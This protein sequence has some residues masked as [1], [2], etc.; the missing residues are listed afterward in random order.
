MNDQCRQGRI[1]RR[2][3]CRWLGFTFGLRTGSCLERRGER[4]RER[5][6]E[7][8]D[9]REKEVGDRE[10]KGGESYGEILEND[11]MPA[12]LG[13][14]EQRRRDALGTHLE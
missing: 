12:F 4:E 5:K 3:G 2:G 13:P 10:A 1:A 9:E 6:V 11:F 8:G 7:R 14:G